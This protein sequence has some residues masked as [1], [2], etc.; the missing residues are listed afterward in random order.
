MSLREISVS[1]P[2]FPGEGFPPAFLHKT[3]GKEISFLFFAVYGVL[4]AEKYGT[5]SIIPVKEIVG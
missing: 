4:L 3:P 2:E 5:K 1:G